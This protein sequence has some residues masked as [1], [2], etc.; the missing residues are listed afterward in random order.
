[1]LFLAMR[2]KID[3]VCLQEHN[4]GREKVM[5]AAA[6]R[7]RVGGY[8]LHMDARPERA[9]RGGTAVLVRT[10]SESVVVVGP[11]ETLGDGRG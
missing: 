7:A 5:M 4:W 9:T 8:V 3:I 11:C 1:M 2:S 10:D 6:M